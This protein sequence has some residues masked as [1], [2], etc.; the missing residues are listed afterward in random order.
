MKEATIDIIWKGTCK[1]RAQSILYQC[2]KIFY[3]GMKRLNVFADLAATIGGT[4][5][6]SGADQNNKDRENIYNEINCKKQAHLE[7]W[8]TLENIFCVAEAVENW[9]W[10]FYI[11]IIC[12]YCLTQLLFST[13]FLRRLIDK[14]L[15]KE[16]FFTFIVCV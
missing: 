5:L 14:L 12:Y 15:L 4:G 1:L 8:S 3:F 10:W 9:L 13:R 16:F 7:K 6:F 11:V 2:N